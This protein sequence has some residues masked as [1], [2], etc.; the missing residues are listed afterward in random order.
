MGDLIP[1]SLGGYNHFL[2]YLLYKGYNILAPNF[3][4]STGYGQKHVMKAVTKNGVL[5]KDEVLA[6]L[7]LALERKLGNPK[8][9]CVGR[10]SYGGFLAHA[11]MNE[12]PDLFKVALIRNPSINRLHL[13]YTSD[14]PELVFAEAFNEG[15]RTNPKIEQL[16]KIWETSP[17]SKINREIRTRIQLQLGGNDRRVPPE[18]ALDYFRR[19]KKSGVQIECHYY[20][21]EGHALMSSLGNEFDAAMKRIIFLEEH[22]PTG[23]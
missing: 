10:G 12:K 4:G 23:N 11:V 17:A 22:L 8:K 1:Q 16:I 3:S 6:V 9:L 2:H 14:V 19:L 20:P 21:Y 13:L 15:Y 5:D 7:D 18:G